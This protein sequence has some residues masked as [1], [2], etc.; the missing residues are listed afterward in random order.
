MS[1]PTYVGVYTDSSGCWY[2]GDLPYAKAVFF[3][4]KKE[5]YK[6]YIT[7]VRDI[8]KYEIMEIPENV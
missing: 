5:A 7:Y 2:E 4:S 3:A 6:W 8:S 1:K